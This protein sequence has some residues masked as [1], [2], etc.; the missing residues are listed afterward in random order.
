MGGEDQG[1]GMHS[2]TFLQTDCGYHIA[3]LFFWPVKGQNSALV[4]LAV[5]SQERGKGTGEMGLPIS[6]RLHNSVHSAEE[7]KFLP[8]QFAD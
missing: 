4:H 7:P 1:F 6:Q 3:L 8:A 2:S 5:G